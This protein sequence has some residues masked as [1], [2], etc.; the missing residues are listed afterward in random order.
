MIGQLLADDPDDD[1]LMQIQTGFLVSKR[2]WCDFISYSGGLPMTTI[3]VLPDMKIQ[4]AIISAAAAFEAKAA[5]A[6][7]DYKAAF[8][9]GMRML[10]TKR[11]VEL[12]MFA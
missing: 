4:G 2:K 3:R 7:A 12:E 6:L 9:S 10:P 1:Y 5:E 11:R 8:K